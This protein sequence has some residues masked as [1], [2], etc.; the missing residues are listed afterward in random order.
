MFHQR[1]DVDTIRIG[2]R[3]ST[4]SKLQAISVGQKLI[5]KNQNLKIEYFFRE[6]L[7]DKNLEAPLQSLSGQGVF[8]RELE[9]D[10]HTN[11]IDLIVHSWKDLDL[12]ERPG[13][14]IFSVLPRADQRDLILFKPEIKTCSEIQILSSSPRRTYQLHS[15]LKDHLPL[16][17]RSKDINFVSVRGNIQTRLKKFFNSES[18]GIVIAKAAIDRLLTPILL[19][20]YKEEFLRTSE[21][22]RESLN[23]CLFIIP[24]LSI[25]PNAP[26][27]G[28]L[29]AQIREN[30]EKLANYLKEIQDMETETCSVKEREA[31]RK[32]GGGCHQKIG[33]SYL[34]RP[35]GTIEYTN[36]E[37]EDNIQI[38][39]RRILNT[40]IQKFH[41]SEVWP[42]NAKMA[43]RQR[44]RLDFKIPPNSN[45][46]VG[47][48]YAFP[49]DLIIHS[50]KQIIWTAGLT[51]WKDLANRDVWVNGTVDGLGE[52]EPIGID[53]M[54]GYK[55]NF[56]KLSHADSDSNFSQYP[57]IS[58]YRV[59]SPEIPSDFDPSKIKAAFW[60]SSTEYEIITKKYPEL[61]SVIH[62]VGPG[63]TYT[64]LKRELGKQAESR[65]FV[66]LSYED[67]HAENT[68]E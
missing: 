51:T 13:S 44:E 35:Y 54:L 18:T 29:A 66:S 67:W 65:I 37:T 50:P 40:K 52:A 34:I 5:E 45:F 22:V 27:Q 21:F 36:G 6:T 63:S 56:V 28:T 8:T 57:L 46:F 61:K 11:K 10:L 16:S 14:S 31:L 62:F 26:A 33:V 9:D 30:D 1:S 20:E 53:T 24:P 60:R 25:C 12:E 39:E 49:S 58:T 4:L 38:S 17:L 3:S 2:A 48:G 42:P 23:Q 32:Y 64:K 15:F 7:G 47:R 68:Y 19:K 41:R 55:A 43:G 59:S